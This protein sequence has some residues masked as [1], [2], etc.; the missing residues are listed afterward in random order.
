MV[1]AAMLTSAA[2]LFTTGLATFASAQ[3]GAQLTLTPTSGGPNTFV[4]VTGDGFPPNSPVALTED[5]AA[6][7]PN[8][9]MTDANGHFAI[10]V[11]VRKTTPGATTFDASADGRLAEA[12]F[13]VQAPNI[14]LLPGSAPPGSTV[15]ITGHGFFGA[16]FIRSVTFDG[17]PVATNPTPIPT[18][19][20]GNFHAS[21]TVPAGAA[22]GNHTVVATGQMGGTAQAPFTV[23]APNALALNPTQGPTGTVVTASGTGFNPNA[24]IT[25]TFDNTALVTNPAVPVTDATG[26]FTATFSVPAG[27]A[28]GAHTVTATDGQLVQQAAFTVTNA[29]N[30]GATGTTVTITGSGYPAGG[31]VTVAFD[32]TA[33]QTNPSPLVADANGG[34]A[35]TFTVP[36]GAT[37]GGHTVT[38]TSGGTQVGAV[39][40]VTVAAAPTISASPTSPVA[41]QSVTVTGSGF[42][43]NATVTVTG[44]DYQTASVTSDANGNFAVV[45]VDVNP[46]STGLA[47][48]T[49]TDNAGRTAQTQVNVVA[50]PPPAAAPTVNVNPS[51]VTAGQAAIVSG[52]GFP[53]STTAQAVAF[54]T[55]VL[56]GTFTTDGAG[57]FSGPVVIPLTE[58]P[59]VHELVV[60]AANGVTGVALFTVSGVVNPIGGSA[61]PIVGSATPIL[62]PGAAI[63]PAVAP[64]SSSQQQQQQSAAAAAPASTGS[65]PVASPATAAPSPQTLPFTGHATLRDAC[66]AGLAVLVG[67]VMLVASRRRRAA[68]TH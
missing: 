48:I 20:A 16:D 22:V 9:L 1:A 14:F 2:L 58:T 60:T 52:S 6:I 28:T 17:T 47:T 31:A 18:D 13:T 53:P 44:T 38:A 30:S 49:A 19:D 55:P 23:A 51:V 29:P 57:N 35:A 40:T 56:L 59:G 4:T 42:T 62:V 39:F 50:A 33:V 26:A 27:A 41:G 5:G 21:F 36:A 67:A 12:V 34:F 32:G 63:T 7:G 46:T 11:R 25:M 68:R 10:G 54:S 24:N 8:N 3:A 15:S 64:A 61:N 45:L 66:T 37:A 65:T 43:P